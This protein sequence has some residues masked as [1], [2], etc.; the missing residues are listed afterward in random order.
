MVMVM[1]LLRLCILV[2]NPAPSC[3]LVNNDV[4]TNGG[5]VLSIVS[6]GQDHNEAISKSY[7]VVEKVNYK[8]KNYRRDIGF[9]L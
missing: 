6:K 7:K 8:D 3:P 5:R 1:I 4:L 9:D 2:A